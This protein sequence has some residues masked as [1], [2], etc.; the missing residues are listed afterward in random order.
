MNYRTMVAC[1]ESR[2]VSRRTRRALE[3]Y[4]DA[5]VDCGEKKDD[6]AGDIA[7]KMAAL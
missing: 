5:D 7:E 1:Y 4:G 3:E 2:H 6:D